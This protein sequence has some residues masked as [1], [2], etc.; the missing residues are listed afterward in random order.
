MTQH[1]PSAL[2]E[3]SALRRHGSSCCLR[4]A[5]PAPTGP[6]LL[7]DNQRYACRWAE[8]TLQSADPGVTLGTGA[9]VNEE[10]RLAAF[11]PRLAP[12]MQTA[13]A[14]PAN[15][16]PEDAT[17]EGR[18]RSI[19]SRD[20]AGGKVLSLNEVAYASRREEAVPVGQRATLMGRGF[21]STSVSRTSHRGERLIAWWRLG[22]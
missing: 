4:A 2:Q 15:A 21:G 13:T 12:A 17:A 8:A 9:G 1:L 22:A 14:M 20:N 7:F 3:V 11:G 19:T 18:A 16:S 5:K 6:H 10:A